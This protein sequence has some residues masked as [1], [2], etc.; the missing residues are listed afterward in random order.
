MLIRHPYN[1]K[2][3]NLSSLQLQ[4]K[5]CLKHWLARNLPTSIFR[6][7]WLSH[8][9]CLYLNSPLTAESV[10]LLLQHSGFRGKWGG[11]PS[12][13]F[14]HS[15]NPVLFLATGKS[16][17]SCVRGEVLVE[18]RGHRV[19]CVS[20]CDPGASPSVCRVGFLM[21]GLGH[22]EPCSS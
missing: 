15:G 10:L 14:T 7:L 19:G 11:G 8:R 1:F 3:V 22:W 16:N 13:L 12:F 5:V 2:N 6:L 18:E 21:R 4:G 20:G 17:L 9:P